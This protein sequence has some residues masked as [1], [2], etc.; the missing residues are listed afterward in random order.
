[1]RLLLLLFAL[2]AGLFAKEDMSV[3]LSY[4]QGYESDLKEILIGDFKEYPNTYSAIS[5]DLGYLISKADDEKIFDWYVYYGLAVFDEGNQQSDIYEN[6]LY[7]KG[8][9][10]FKGLNK[11]IRLGFAEGLSYTDGIL[12]VEYID[13]TSAGG[14]G[15]TSHLLNYLDLSVDVDMGRLLESKNMQNVNLGLVIKHRSGIFGLF[16][17]VN[18]G[19]NYPGFYIE[20]RF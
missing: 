16:N 10:T 2:F 12:S 6:A 20:K 13:A 11:S 7:I 3:R 17:G 8:F 15:K 5:L 1:M 14:D 19:S 4:T 18:G 9:Y